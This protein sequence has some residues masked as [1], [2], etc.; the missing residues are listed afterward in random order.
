VVVSEIF[1]LT[2]KLY[3]TFNLET[4]DAFG[5]KGF[6]IQGKLKIKESSVEE[7]K[8][9]DS[10]I[11]WHTLSIAQIFI[12]VLTGET[13]GLLVLEYVAIICSRVCFAIRTNCPDLFLLNSLISIKKEDISSFIGEITKSPVA[14]SNQEPRDGYVFR[15]TAQV[16]DGGEQ[17]GV[18]GIFALPVAVEIHVVS[19]P[20]PENFVIT[21]FILNDI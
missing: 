14:V 10:K 9:D 3:F 12:A 1:G 7:L 19:T 11:G 8:S 20:L 13:G 21:G 6:G 18:N 16:A 17:K 15:L 2:Q 4:G 5:A